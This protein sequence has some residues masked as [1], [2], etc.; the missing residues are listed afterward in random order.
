MKNPI[1]FTS[2]CAISAHRF[3][4]SANIDELDTWDCFSKTKIYKHFEQQNWS[5]LD[6]EGWKVISVAYQSREGEPSIISLDQEGYVG[7]FQQNNNEHQEIRFKLEEKIYGQFNKLRTVRQEL[8]ACGDGGQVYLN[9]GD[10]WSNIGFNLEE[11]PLEVTQG[12]IFSLESDFSFERNLYDI[13][14]FAH[15]HLYV[16]GTKGDDGFIAFFNGSNWI[17]VN[18]ITP[19]ALYSITLCP[20]GKSVLISG[21]YGTLLKGNIDDGFKSLKNRSINAIFYNAAFYQEA[22]YIASEQGL[23]VYS[24]S[25][26]SI[27]PELS[28][29]QGVISVEEKDGILWVLSYKQLIRFD[30]K[31]WDKINHPDND[32]IQYSQLKCRVGEICPRSGDWWSPA[33]NMEK[34]HFDQGETMPEIPNNPW[35]ETIWYLDIESND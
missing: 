1:T 33:I 11:Q 5:C 23:Y 30:G 21:Q 4:L 29:I 9:A 27:V 24:D 31:T 16:C 6:L 2:G 32:E 17:E 7:I 35:G 8:Y 15:D 34:R 12:E 19:S 25:E 18:R 20:D 14:G 22:I 3:C 10:S 28:D 13:N 26:Y